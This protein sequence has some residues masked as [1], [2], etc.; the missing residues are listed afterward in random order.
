MTKLIGG[1]LT[2]GIKSATNNK[3]KQITPVAIAISHH[4]S[5]HDSNPE[6]DNTKDVHIRA[7]KSYKANKLYNIQMK[8]KFFALSNTLRGPVEMFDKF[9]L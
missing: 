1:L 4:L 6:Y 3:I 8:F 5:V 2:D 7:I 9:I